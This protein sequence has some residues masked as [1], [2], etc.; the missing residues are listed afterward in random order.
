[1]APHDYSQKNR[2]QRPVEKEA[3][4]MMIRRL[5]VEEEEETKRFCVVVS[6]VTLKHNG[7]DSGHTDSETIN[8]HYQIHISPQ[9]VSNCIAWSRRN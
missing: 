7:K 5:L 6:W 3:N 4:P 8:H 9:Y 2:V 1:M